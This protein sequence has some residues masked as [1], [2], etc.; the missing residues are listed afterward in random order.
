MPIKLMRGKDRLTD[1]CDMNR[2][3][4]RV[5]AGV[6]YIIICETLLFN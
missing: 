4:S 5:R 3:D 1:I 2:H 6:S